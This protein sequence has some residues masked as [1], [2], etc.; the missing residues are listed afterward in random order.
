MVDVNMIK[1]AEQKNAVTGE[2]WTENFQSTRYFWMPNGFGLKQGEAYYQNVWILFNQFNVGIT[3]NF[4]IAGGTIPLF[5]FGADAFPIWVNAKVSVP[6][7]PKVN[8]GGGV[9]CTCTC[10]ILVAMPPAATAVPA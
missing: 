3:K 2:Y 7:G 8:F 5:L 10:W 4:S 1:E 9:L 6:L